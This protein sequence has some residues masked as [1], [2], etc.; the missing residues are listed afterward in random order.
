L[1]SKN[2]K[3]IR[4]NI[5]RIGLIFALLL[6]YEYNPEENQQENS[7]TK[8][9]EE[10]TAKDQHEKYPSESKEEK[11]VNTQENQTHP[12]TVK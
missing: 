2:S 9:N 4:K 10:K 12:L 3:F 5:Y 11:L 1:V 6:T 7:K 8:N